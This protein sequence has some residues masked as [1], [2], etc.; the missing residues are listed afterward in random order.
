[1]KLTYIE[2]YESGQSAGKYDANTG[3]WLAGGIFL[4][5]ISVIVAFSSSPPL[6]THPA[7]QSSNE[8]QLGYVQGYI[9]ARKQ[10]NGL[11]AV[12]GWII[13]STVLGLIILFILLV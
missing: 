8:Y 10:A 4:G 2:G 13:S 9:N 6:S 11:A 5:L 1:V 7:A 12:T 3:N